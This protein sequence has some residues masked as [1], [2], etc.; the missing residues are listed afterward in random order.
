MCLRAAELVVGD[1]AEE[2]MFSIADTS[3]T[4]Y[5]IEED[6]SRGWFFGK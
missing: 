4:C 2:L 6:K 5:W 3:P 1:K